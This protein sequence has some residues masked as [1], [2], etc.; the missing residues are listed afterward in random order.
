M[1]KHHASMTRDHRRHSGDTRTWRRSD[2]NIFATENTSGKR[3]TMDEHG[4][5]AHASVDSQ[6]PHI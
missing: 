6:R 4:K 5:T 1:C 3:M 2:V